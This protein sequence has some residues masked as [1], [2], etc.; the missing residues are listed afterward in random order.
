MK[1]EINFPP[2][3]YILSALFIILFLLAPDP[4]SKQVVLYFS[5]LT[6]VF[7][8]FNFTRSNFSHT[9]GQPELQSKNLF[10]F[11]T[12]NLFLVSVWLSFFLNSPT[13]MSLTAVFGP[14]TFTAICVIASLSLSKA[15]QSETH[16]DRRVSGFAGILAM[17]FIIIFI[18]FFFPTSS[19]SQTQGWSITLDTL[20]NPK[21]ALFGVGP[22]NFPLAL[23]QNR[24]LSLS[25]IQAVNQNYNYSSNFVFQIITE[26][27]LVSFGLLIIAVF[28]SLRRTRRFG[29]VEAIPSESRLLHFVRNDKLTLF[30]RLIFSALYF[31]TLYFAFRFYLAEVN[32]K[33]A[34]ESQKA[35]I[36]YSTY[37]YIF[38]AIKMNK[39]N[40]NYHIFLS[41]IS[42]SSANAIKENND[43]KK[44]LLTQA[45]NEAKYALNLSS[46]NAGNF[47][48]LGN[49]Y[50][51]IKNELAISELTTAVN[52]DPNNSLYHFTL[53]RAFLTFGNFEEAQK[54]FEITTLLDPV[55]ANAY[56]GQYFTL[57]VQKQYP[58]ALKA[59]TMAQKLNPYFKKELV[60]FE[61][62][63][64]Q[65]T[66]S[67]TILQPPV[68]NFGQ[69][70]LLQD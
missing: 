59:I 46:Q 69:L 38:N 5:A 58:Q 11:I 34:Y 49:T 18:V 68:S 10:G 55:F 51:E 24:P 54:Q 25:S 20:K 23:A 56:Y 50:L 4:V 35:Q 70:K 61:S 21:S 2:L 29:G 12:F 44:T 65:A 36:T 27:G 39:Y 53:A 37:K 66:T 52:M 28:V 57:R 19:L 48:T 13:F 47:F 17:T 22:G 43:T 3:K 64:K 1:I 62:Q 7:I 41:K 33:S 26:Y 9:S 63:L 32:Y 60:D 45:E 6:I 31:I 16:W 40:P 30:L 42:L 14:L 15:W 8:T 67:G